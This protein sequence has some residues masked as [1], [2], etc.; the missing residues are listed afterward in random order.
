M[1]F[2]S[3]SLL[4]AATSLGAEAGAREKLSH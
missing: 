1:I 2:T 3:C 4:L